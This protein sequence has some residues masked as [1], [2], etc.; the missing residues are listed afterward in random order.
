MRVANPPGAAALVAGTVAA[1]APGIGTI[2]VL[3]LVPVPA[4]FVSDVVHNA[5]TA[6][7]WPL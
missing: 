2:A 6:L 5:A 1:L 3:A 4:M 7:A